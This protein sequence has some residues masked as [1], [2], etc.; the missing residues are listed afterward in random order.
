VAAPLP[1]LAVPK[2]SPDAVQNAARV[3]RSGQPTLIV[4]AGN[5]CALARWPMRTASPPPPM[6]G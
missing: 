3:L 4:L 5:A 6:R 1:A 2:V